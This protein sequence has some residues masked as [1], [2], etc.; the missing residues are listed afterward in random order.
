M[1]K[2]TQYGLTYKNYKMKQEES[3]VNGNY[4]VRWK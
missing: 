3:T 1:Q 2:L 4:G